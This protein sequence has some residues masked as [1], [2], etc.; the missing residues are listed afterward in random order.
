MSQI[1]LVQLEKLEKICKDFLNDDQI[2]FA[3]VINGM[4]NLVAGGFRKG[5]DP[6]ENDEKRRTLYM[7]MVL[8]ISMRKEFDSTLGPINYIATSRGNTMM[9]TIPVNNRVILIS[10]EPTIVVEKLVTK[11]YT[12]FSDILEQDHG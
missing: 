1:H 4:G 8:E 2:R 6:I 3:G 10:A 11:A 5:I 9:I 12:T 7:Q